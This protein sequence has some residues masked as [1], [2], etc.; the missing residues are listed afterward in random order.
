MIKIIEVIHADYGTQWSHI[1]MRL[2]CDNINYTANWI[3]KV[4][5]EPSIF[6]SLISGPC[7][8]THRLPETN[9]IFKKIKHFMLDWLSLQKLSQ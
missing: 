7:T 2:E 1:Y 9:K 6:I 8:F 3:Y 4:S 5:K